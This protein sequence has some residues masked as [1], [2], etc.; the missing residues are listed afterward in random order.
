MAILTRRVQI[1]TTLVDACGIR[2]NSDGVGECWDTTIYIN[3]ALWFGNDS[4]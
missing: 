3:A 4:V 2:A 1:K